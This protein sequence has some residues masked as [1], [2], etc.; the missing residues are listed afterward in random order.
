MNYPLINITIGYVRKHILQNILLILGIAFGVALI[1]SVDIAN[2]SSNRA[3]SVS[4]E[5]LSTKT[6]HSILGT[7][8]DFDEQI[9]QDLKLKLGIDNMAP[10]VQDYVN[11]LDA[12]GQAVKLLG[13]DFF[14]D[15]VF[16]E[17]AYSPLSNISQDK[18]NKLLTKPG[19]GLIS[20]QLA[21]NKGIEIGTKLKAIYGSK[22]INIEIIGVIDSTTDQ[23]SDSFGGLILTDISTAQML[24]GKL[25]VLSQI[26]LFIEVDTSE[27][28]ELIRS[29]Q[30]YLP[31]GI[32]IKNE[33]MLL[34]SARN[35]TR[36]F[37]L[38]LTALSLLA[39][40]V[41]VFLIYNIVSFS[42][43]QRR[44]IIGT[45]RSIGATRRQIF[46]MIL[47]ETLIIGI[48]GSIAGLFF[49]ILLGRSIVN[50][51]T[52]SIND[53][54]FTLTVTSFTLSIETL[55]KGILAGL[56]AVII[57]AL[58]PAYE[59]SRFRPINI[60]RRS[61][62]ES[63]FIK[64]IRLLSIIGIILLLLGYLLIIAPTKSLLLSLISVFLILFGFSF[65]V[66]LCTTL[67][68][69]LFSIMLSPIGL[70]GRLP[71]R[72][73]IRSTSRTS[74]AI[75]S[76]TIAIAVILSISIMIGSFRSTVV[77]WLDSALTADIFISMYS[78]N[79][80]SQVGLDSQIIDEIS[81]IPGVLKVA[82]VTRLLY[83]SEDYGI[84]NIVAVTKD[85]AAENRDFIWRKSNNADIWEHMKTDSILI[86][87]SFSYR[88]NINPGENMILN[89]QTDRGARDFQ[90][91]G[92]YY[93]YGAQG[94]VIL[95]SDDL[96]R[97][98]WND[99]K[100]TSLGVYATKDQDIE[101]LAHLL[102]A[103]LSNYSNLSIR[104]NDNLKKSAIN[105]FDRT[106][107]V[108]SALRLL[109]AIVAFLSVLSALM[110][111]QLERSREFGVYRAIGMTVLQL[112][113]M[114]LFENGLI[115]IASGLFS[116]PLG[117]VISL[118]LI[119]VVNLR[120]FGWTLNFILEP[121]YFIEAIGIALAASIAAGLYPCYL[122]GKVDIGKLIREE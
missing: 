96:Y 77:N 9:Y 111:L 82:S 59:A 122:I 81:N 20:S 15:L 102:R 98:L 44:Y 99:N 93:D 2:E 11:L 13:T 30:D 74:V 23:I 31:T 17:R 7:Y 80:S 90:V 88:N 85:L 19:T 70:I 29:I 83:D 79:I 63:I 65:L 57:A 25:G 112:R 49:G 50:M 94:G 86:S 61:A 113:G 115:G 39:L 103:D 72:N 56:L 4:K 6:T 28:N 62:L 109:I 38:N 121:R 8:S 36:S 21:Q 1:V 106:F 66:P 32:H 100:I 105:T 3:F 107:T 91:A 69:W 27:G 92:I 54:Y 75:A 104:S 118:I 67:L 33:D 18:I 22:I 97:T 117:L 14:A 34:G 16:Y 43:V 76:L 60:L 41:G 68:M 46:K 42:V 116:I 10:I 73:I 84:F 95:V 89:L 78:T 26:D 87:E 37:E 64:Y 101:K 52:R 35:L 120:S 71:P 119:Y 45:L 58:I 47:V 55:V 108:T 51:V 24:L 12:D 110:A 53:L 48:T 114:L 40:F 5:I